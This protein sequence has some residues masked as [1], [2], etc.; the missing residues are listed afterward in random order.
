MQ[1]TY[2]ISALTALGFFGLTNAVPA[3]APMPQFA[4]TPPLNGGCNTQHFQ[5]GAKCYAENNAGCSVNG[6]DVVS[7]C[8]S[9]SLDDVTDHYLGCL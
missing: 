5:E 9:F 4:G 3:P 8:M 6:W 7:P 2:I 1:Y